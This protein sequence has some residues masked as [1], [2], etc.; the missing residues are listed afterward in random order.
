MVNRGIEQQKEIDRMIQR[1]SQAMHPLRDEIMHG[2]EKKLNS[3]IMREPE[4][5]NESKS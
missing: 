1:T 2:L 4:K 5:T 3:A